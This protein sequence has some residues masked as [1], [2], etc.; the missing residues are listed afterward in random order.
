[1]P[2]VAHDNYCTPRGEDFEVSDVQD[3]KHPQRLS[4]CVVLTMSNLPWLLAMAM[5]RLRGV[6]VASWPLTVVEA[7]S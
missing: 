1:M 2:A 6:A 5:Q 4:T 7:A 3:A